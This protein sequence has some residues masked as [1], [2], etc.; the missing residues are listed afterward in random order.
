M[1]AHEK[2][3]TKCFEGLDRLPV[4][5]VDDGDFAAF[6]VRRREHCRF[7]VSPGD[8]GAQVRQARATLDL[9]QVQLD[10][11]ALGR[12]IGLALTL[13]HENIFRATN[14]V[15]APSILH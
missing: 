14:E 4:A 9:T 15:T 7:S 5:H 13:Q 3:G 10:I 6:Q 1:A 8:A 2:A 11:E 12:Q